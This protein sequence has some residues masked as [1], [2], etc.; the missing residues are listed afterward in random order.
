MVLFIEQFIRHIGKGDNKAYFGEAEYNFC[1][2]IFFLRQLIIAINRFIWPWNKIND[3]TITRVYCCSKCAKFYPAINSYCYDEKESTLNLHT[4]HRKLLG[5]GGHFNEALLSSLH[6][7]AIIK[8]ESKG[9][10]SKKLESM[11]NHRET[12]AFIPNIFIQQIFTNAIHLFLHRRSHI[13]LIQ[14]PKRNYCIDFW[15]LKVTWLSLSLE[16]HQILNC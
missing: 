16:F 15:A 12:K 9:L 10:I 5:Y 1:F 7:I 2:T 14:N 4:L 3:E 11:C 13:Y 6:C 8:L